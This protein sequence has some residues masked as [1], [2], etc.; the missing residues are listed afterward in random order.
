MALLRSFPFLTRLRRASRW[1]HRNLPPLN[2]IT[3]HYTYFIVTCLLFSVIFWGASTPS[4][5]VDFTDAIF[6]VVSAM[7][8]A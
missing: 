8:L 3:L 5:S 6:L 1:L 4:R 7:T 2:F